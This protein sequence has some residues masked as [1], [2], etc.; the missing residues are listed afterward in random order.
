[1]SDELTQRADHILEAALERTGAPDPRPTC[2]DRLRALK[3][4]DPDRYASAVDFYRDEL[5][6]AVASGEG[7]PIVAWVEYGRTLA[8]ALEAGRTVSIDQTGRAHPYE[9][10]EPSRL[11]LHLP[12][13][14]GTPALLVSFPPRPSPAQ[15]ATYDVLVERRVRAPD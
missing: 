7:D 12:D 5:L 9:G 14:R 2:R 1:M 4:A 10:P 6:P 15:Q 11:V 13:R 3:D 8:Q